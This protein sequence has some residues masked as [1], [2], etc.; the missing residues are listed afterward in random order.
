MFH[1]IYLQYFKDVAQLSSGLQFQAST[2]ITLIFV[3]LNKCDF[4][5]LATFKI[6]SAFLVFSNLI[7]RRFGVVFTV[8]ILPVVHRTS[9]ICGFTVS[10]ISGVFSVIISSDIFVSPTP[11][12]FLELQLYIC[13]DHLILFYRLL[14]LCSFLFQSFGLCALVSIAVFKFTDHFFY[15]I[16]VLLQPRHVFFL[17]IIIL[18]LEVLFDF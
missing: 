6:C 18:S 2:L 12:F 7:T 11:T 8:F 1:C 13:L 16:L 17:Y 15:R 14:R 10:T 3:S 5:P 4:F 9:W